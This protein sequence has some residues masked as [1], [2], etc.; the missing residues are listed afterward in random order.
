MSPPWQATACAS[1]PQATAGGLLL[2]RLVRPSP[3]VLY[4]GR[5]KHGPRGRSPCLPQALYIDRR[6]HLELAWRRQQ[7]EEARMLAEGDSCPLGCITEVRSLQHLDFLIEC[8]GP[9]VLIIAFYSR[10]SG[11]CK[12]MLDYFAELCREASQQKSGVLFLKHNLRDDFD[13]LTEV[14]RMYRTS[15]PAFVFLVDGAQL[16][17]VEMMDGRQHPSTIQRMLTW[18]RRRL[19]STLQ[20]MLFRNAPSAR[21]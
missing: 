3:H 6:Q 21:R 4:T 1:L 7:S 16:R 15:R 17:K 13:N 11:T 12:A 14:A 20:E 18:Q 2:S 10:S 8:A 19:N 5:W 9:S